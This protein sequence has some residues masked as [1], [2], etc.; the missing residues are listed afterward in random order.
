[1]SNVSASLP[2]RATMDNICNL[3]G[4][5]LLDICLSSDLKI[6]NGRIGNDAGIGRYTFMSSQ[7]PSLIDYVL[8][9][10]ALFPIINS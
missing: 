8:A 5:K 2:H 1:M 4:L 9:S 6:V 3:S 7:S 10:Y